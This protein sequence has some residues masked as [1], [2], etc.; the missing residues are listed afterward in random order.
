MA[1]KTDIICSDII[2]HIS[3]H[4]ILFMNCKNDEANEWMKSIIEDGVSCLCEDESDLGV[5]IV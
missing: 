3:K 5:C 1:I 4:A 2:L